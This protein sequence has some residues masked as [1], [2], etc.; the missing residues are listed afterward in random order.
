MWDEYIAHMGEVR[1]TRRISVWRFNEKIPQ[2]EIGRKFQ[3]GKVYP[4]KAAIGFI[5]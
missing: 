3:S 2:K 4:S 5:C 1:N